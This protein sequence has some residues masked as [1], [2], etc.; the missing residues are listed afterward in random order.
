MYQ[1]LLLDAAW[2]N[3]KQEISNANNV[4]KGDQRDLTNRSSVEHSYAYPSLVFPSSFVH[5]LGFVAE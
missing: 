4:P 5:S 3:D 2:R 1:Q